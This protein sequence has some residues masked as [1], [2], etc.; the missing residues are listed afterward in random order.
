MTLSSEGMP[1]HQLWP[2]M[3]WA[4]AE[5]QRRGQT[6]EEL[7]NYLREEIRKQVLGAPLL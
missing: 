6:V 2:L 7:L 5:T 1:L 3:D 4:R